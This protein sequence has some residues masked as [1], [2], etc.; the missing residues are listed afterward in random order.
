MRTKDFEYRPVNIAARSKSPEPTPSWIEICSIPGNHVS[1]I[2][3]I[4][5]IDKSG[6]LSINR[7]LPATAIADVNTPCYPSTINSIM[8]DKF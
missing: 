2:R 8:N 1:D 3:I 5:S 6:P 7:S 4:D